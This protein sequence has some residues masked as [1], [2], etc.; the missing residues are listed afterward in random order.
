LYDNDPRS[1]TTRS[2]IDCHLEND[3][4]TDHMHRIVYCSNQDLSPP[5]VGTAHSQLSVIVRITT[6]HLLARSYCNLGLDDLLDSQNL[7][8]DAI[9]LG[10]GSREIRLDALE[11]LLD[12]LQVLQDLGQVD[13]RRADRGRSGNRSSG[14]SV[15][16]R[17]GAGLRTSR[18]GASGSGGRVSGGGLRLGV[19]LLDGDRGD[20]NSAGSGGSCGRSGSLGLGSG[21]LRDGR[22]GGLGGGRRSLH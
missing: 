12:V 13:D 21:R 5:C 4:K 14:L 15:R 3:L 20:N 18:G 19:G 1:Y 6:S 10:L 11:F 17:D 16:D 2:P 7:G 9:Q 8:L 22:F